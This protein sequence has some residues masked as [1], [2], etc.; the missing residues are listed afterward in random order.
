MST[1]YIKSWSNERAWASKGSW[2]LKAYCQ[3]IQDCTNLK[4]TELKRVARLIMSK[5]LHKIENVNKEKAVAIRHT[6][7]SSGAEVEIK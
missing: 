7:E 3:R 4:G 2:P 5:E 1:L 6:L